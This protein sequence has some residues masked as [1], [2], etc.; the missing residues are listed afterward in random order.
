MT[1]KTYLVEDSPVIRDNL[2]RFLQDIVHAEVVAHASTEKEAVA[3][4]T[5]NHDQ[6]DVAIVDLF[7]AQG[8]GL[9]VVDACRDR[10]T[11]QK[12]VVLTNYATPAMRVRAKALGADAFFDKSAEIDELVEYCGRLG[13][14]LR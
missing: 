1:F 13:A 3:W 7:L 8:N 11:L 2:V 4:L 6:W 10:S 12:V 14:A 5:S 9:D